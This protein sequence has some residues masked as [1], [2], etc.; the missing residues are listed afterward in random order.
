MDLL[1]KSHNVNGTEP[2][3]PESPV[4][5]ALMVKIWTA[6]HLSLCFEGSLGNGLLMILILT[7]SKLRIGC[8]LLIVHCLAA[9]TILCA[10]SF[11]VVAVSIYLRQI[12][13]WKIYPRDCNII[14]WIQMTARYT[15]TGM[16]LLIAA[17]RL[18]ARCYPYHYRDLSK[19]NL[20][21][22]LV[23]AVWL[24]GGL[25]ALLGWFRVGTAN[26]VI[27]LGACVQMPSSRIGVMVFVAGF[28]LPAAITG[29]AY[30][31][32]YSYASA[33]ITHITS[34]AVHVLALWLSAV[35]LIGFA[36][37]PPICFVMNKDY[38]D[39]LH[40]LACKRHR[41]SAQHESGRVGMTS[42]VHKDTVVASRAISS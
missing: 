15:A 35:Q 3:E 41:T 30:I 24:F 31:A 11:P 2:F 33:F 39:E 29:A 6:V 13:G 12:Y 14:Q 34:E 28:Y 32:L 23:I 4:V 20:E 19:K 40:R 21:R 18:A 17:N 38:R 42:S 7:N 27:L 9:Y 22:W 25:L 10:V 26:T 5:S 16:D 36:G 37:N 1:N 8:G